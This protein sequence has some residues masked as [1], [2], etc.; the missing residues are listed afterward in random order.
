MLVS[1]NERFVRAD[2]E[3]EAEIERVVQQF[4]SHLFGDNSIYL[5]QA[6]ISTHGGVGTIPDAVV[7]DVASEEWYVVEAE[8]GVHGTWQHIAPQVSKQLAAVR[9]E[10][11]KERI[12][13]LALRQV[14]EKGEVRQM[15]AE[16]G[17][18]DI[19]I[20]QRLL[21]ILRKEPTIA[22]PID[23][24]P[25]DLTEWIVTL[26]N[27]AKIW[28]IEKYVSVDDPTQ[29]LYSI[30]DESLPTISTRSDRTG[31][32]TTVT[33]GSSP[34]Q[35]LWGSGAVHDGMT[36]MMTYGPRGQD[37]RTYQGLARENG[38]EVDGEIF[39]PSYAAVHC[40]QKAGS[41]RKTANGWTVWRTE[42]GELL[43]DLYERVMTEDQQAHGDDAGARFESPA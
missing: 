12:L 3:N 18:E 15:L 31:S 4:A 28:I 36:L 34:W 11:T 2:F 23:F 35:D 13:D 17:I 20:H 16:L 5:P 10:A 19:A 22:I 24:V 25:K 6:R 30:P 32:V 9:T 26:R 40:I 1:D 33:R 27:R 38:I 7:I 43:N 21:E 14:K 39:A 29:V 42:G 8:R 41:D 37:K